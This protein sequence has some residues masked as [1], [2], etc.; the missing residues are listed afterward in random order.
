MVGWKAIDRKEVGMTKDL[1]LERELKFRS[2]L[3]GF[4]LV[5]AIFVLAL[6]TVVGFVFIFSR[7]EI[8]GVPYPLVTVL[9][10]ALA[11][12]PVVVM[13]HILTRDEHSMIEIPPDEWV[14]LALGE[15]SVVDEDW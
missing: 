14:P 4:Y 11:F 1:D 10:A 7:P 8:L 15:D 3:L 6:V 13:R 5:Y 9:I 2:T 12:A